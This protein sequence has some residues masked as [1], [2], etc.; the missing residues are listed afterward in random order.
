MTNPKGVLIVTHDKKFHLDEVIAVMFLQMLYQTVN[1]TVV[2]T[3]DPDIITK[4]DF[5]VDVGGEYDPSR[6]RFDHHQEGFNKTF[7]GVRGKIP[8]ASSGLVWLHYGRELLQI[9][10]A[11]FG[12][13]L[14][15]SQLQEAYRQ[16]YIAVLMEIDANDN[17]VNQYQK[18]IE[19]NYN[20]NLTLIGTVSKFNGKNICDDDTQL[21][22]FYRA[23]DYCEITLD[24]HILN[25]LRRIESYPT[26]LAV[27][28]NGILNSRRSEI[29]V[30]DRFVP[31]INRHLKDLKKNDIV[32]MISPDDSG[33][34][35]VM[36]I[37][38]SG[39]EFGNV[40]DILPF[41][42]LQ[43]LAPEMG[44]QFKY[45]HNKRF[46]GVAYTQEAAIRMAELSL[47]F[48]CNQ[49]AEL[50]LKEISEGA[51]AIKGS[52]QPVWIDIQT[53]VRIRQMS[54]H[55]KK[56]GY[57]LNLIEDQKGKCKWEFHGT[58]GVDHLMTNNLL[59]D[60]GFR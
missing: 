8:L 6:G 15:K 42:A 9:Y 2:R 60:Y 36:A 13:S 53:G 32:F 43:F 28:K 52:T 25:Q 31:N 47:K 58:N 14:N 57:N 12:I 41:T 40:R 39:A 1:V 16:V 49:N 29:L 59:R 27:V 24:I 54:E 55:G 23:L 22:N 51:Y 35:N 11:K 18:N 38:K 50:N 7:P 48:T 4:A 5:A 3:R 44:D 20:S 34:W 33:E 45:V 30:V 10:C 21:Q 19:K 37:S 17:G 46:M 26:D 56:L